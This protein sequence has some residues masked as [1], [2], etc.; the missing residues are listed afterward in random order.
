M[1]QKKKKKKKNYVHWLFS[2]RSRAI[3]LES[4]PRDYISSTE[5]NNKSRYYYTSH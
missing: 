5:E 2:M 1:F 3:I 4:G